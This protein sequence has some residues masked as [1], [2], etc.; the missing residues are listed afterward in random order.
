MA[1][2]RSVRLYLADGTATGILTAEIMNWTGH[3]LAAPRTR[4][5]DALGRS[6]LKRTG[7][8]LLYGPDDQ[9]SSLTRVY[10][11]EGDEIGKRLYEHNKSKDY[12]DHF[13]AVTSKDMN[14]TKAHVRFLEG[15]VIGLIESA[16]RSVI[17]NS[18]APSFELLPEADISDMHTFLEE[19]QL[20]F[21]VIGFDLLKQQKSKAGGTA[22]RHTATQLEPELA[23]VTFIL[24]N[25]GAGISARAVESEGEFVLMAGSVGSLKEKVSFNEKVKSF[26]D[27]AKNFGIMVHEGERNFRLCEDVSFGS[28]SAAAVF[29]FGTSRNGRTDWIVEGR[30]VNYGTWKQ[31]LIDAMSAHKGMEN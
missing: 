1:N 29:L 18:T 31:E 14:L 13:I 6:E 8:Y 10:V 19:M 5:E 28:P 20:I 7:V 17:D 15:R 30:N 3:V 12:W 4:L 16:K 22:I 9:G 26:R 23:E 24:E 27:E 25:K 2:G 11:G 21:P